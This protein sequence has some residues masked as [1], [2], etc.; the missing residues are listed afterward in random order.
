V[1]AEQPELGADL[2]VG[3]RAVARL[4]AARARRHAAAG[5]GL[6]GAHGAHDLRAQLEGRRLVGGAAARVLG[7]RRGELAL[8]AAT[9]REH[10]DDRQQHAGEGRRYEGEAAAG[11]IGSGSLH[12]T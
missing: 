5:R 6:A 3:L 7:R 4:T 1:L 8:A 11:A 2:F 12:G 10:G 9:E